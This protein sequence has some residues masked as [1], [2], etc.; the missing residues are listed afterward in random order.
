MGKYAARCV[1]SDLAGEEN[2]MLDFCFTT[3]THVTSFFGYRTALLGLYNAQ[4]LPTRG[5]EIILRENGFEN[6]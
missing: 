4:S 3:F 1:V 6:I 5:V 2:E